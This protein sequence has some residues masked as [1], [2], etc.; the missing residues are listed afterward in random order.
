MAVVNKFNVNKQQVTLDA[1]IIENMSANDVSYNASTQYDENTVGDKL[2]KLGQQVIYDVTENND[3]ATFS[4]LSALLSDEN[5]STLIPISVRCGGMTIRFIN[6][7]DN[8]YVQYRYM[9]TVTTDNHNLFLDEDNWQGV[10][11]PIDDVQNSI[12]S[13]KTIIGNYG[14]YTPEIVQGM[15]DSEGKPLDSNIYSIKTNKI[16]FNYVSVNVSNGTC[17][18]YIFKQNG[19]FVRKANDNPVSSLEVTRSGEEYYI[20]V[21]F[22]NT[23]ITEIHPNNYSS[24]NVSFVL[25]S[26]IIEDIEDLNEGLNVTNVKLNSLSDIFNKNIGTDIIIEQGIYNDNGE[27]VDNIY[28]IRTPLM[29]FEYLKIWTTTNS[30]GFYCTFVYDENKRFLGKFNN[31]TYHRGVDVLCANSV[32]NE[33]SIKYVAFY[34]VNANVKEITPQD[35][36]SLNIKLYLYSGIKSG[37]KKKISCVGDSITFGYGNVLPYPS[38]LS[39]YYDS[40]NLGI[41]TT[42]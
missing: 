26:G 42:E 18:G 22:F 14:S 39:P 9:E 40:V 4:S 11:K 34:F 7:S 15:Y 32:Y 37:M 30:D 13:L 31:S 20:S 5:L 21:V 1:D 24:L 29:E 16:P 36:D 19:E 17:I 35:F 33:G 2:S 38:F 12:N 10:D 8:K 27:P 25:R 41:S 3:G 23:D 28:A 6:S